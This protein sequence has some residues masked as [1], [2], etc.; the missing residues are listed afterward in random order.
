MRDRLKGLCA[1]KAAVG[2]Q[3]G[4]R[5]VDEP[6]FIEYAEQVVAHTW[7]LKKKKKAREMAEARLTIATMRGR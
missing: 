5:D 1:L 4:G 3:F 6:S 7:G 2:V